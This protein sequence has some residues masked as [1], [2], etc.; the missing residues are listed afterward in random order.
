MSLFDLRS[1]VFLGSFQAAIN[2]AQRI[3]P[4]DEREQIERDILLYRAYCEQGGES[5]DIVLGD[6]RPNSPPPLLAMRVYASYLA[7][8]E[9]ALVTVEEWL[10]QSPGDSITQLVAG[11]ILLRASRNSDAFTV[12]FPPRS[13][14]AQYLIVQ[15][16][17]RINRIDA[18]LAALKIMQEKADDAVPTQVARALVASENRDPDAA[19]YIWKDLLEKYGQNV[20]VLN[21]LGVGHMQR[22]DFEAAEQVLQDALLLDNKSVPTRLNL[23]VCSQH[24]GRPADKWNRDFN[25][26]CSLAPTHPWVVAQQEAEQ[27]FEQARSK[28]Q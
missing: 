8:D 20:L 21:G 3:Q 26:L 25:Q 15:L 16:Y 2:L 27:L 5:L 7:G 10:A 9:K 14:E 24:L 28:Y 1:S 6:I 11:L 13:L 18:A 19:I 4:E 23:L 12:L 17:L 22:G